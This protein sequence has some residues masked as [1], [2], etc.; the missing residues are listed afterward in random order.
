MFNI[1]RAIAV[2]RG[3]L[4]LLASA[5]LGLLIIREAFPVIQD[6]FGSSWSTQT[7]TLFLTG[8][9]VLIL[10]VGGALILADLMRAPVRLA[11]SNPVICS[12]HLNPSLD[13]LSEKDVI[14]I[15]EGL[16]RQ[17][18]LYAHD[19]PTANI[20]LLVGVDTYMRPNSK[21]ERI[22]HTWEKL[23][24][25]DSKLLNRLYLLEGI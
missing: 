10:V 22:K 3:K 23:S 18:L 4:A 1:A 15:R 8:A 25:R 7:P 2:V 12:T 11:I 14:A 6:M 20:Q 9:I 13:G 24:E 17:Y 19:S 5:T 16:A 21:G